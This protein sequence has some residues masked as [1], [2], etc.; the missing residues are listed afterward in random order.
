MLDCSPTQ[1]ISQ[2]WRLHSR[3]FS[4]TRRTDPPNP[5]RRRASTPHGAWDVRRSTIQ[6]HSA[7]PRGVLK[8]PDFLSLARQKGMHHTRGHIVFFL[9]RF[10]LPAAQEW[11]NGSPSA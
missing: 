4:R 10:C 6:P 11:S 7:I 2:I 1:T 5:A 9:F 3:S 8:V